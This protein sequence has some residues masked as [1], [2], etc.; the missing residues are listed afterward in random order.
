MTFF[1]FNDDLYHHHHPLHPAADRLCFRS[2]FFQNE[3]TL[4]YSSFTAGLDR[5]AVVDRAAHPYSRPI[6]HAAP[7]WH[8]RVD[9]DRAGGLAGTGIEQI[10]DRRHQK[11]ID[12]GAAA[13]AGARL[14]DGLRLSIL[15][16]RHQLPRR[17]YQCRSAL[18]DQQLDRH[19]QC[20]IFKFL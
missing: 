6:G 5:A 2:H 11:S 7:V 3:D 9:I 13:H 14:A 18:R 10:E 8:H 20:E 17:T 12:R 4:R 16:G 1:I 19:T 15:P